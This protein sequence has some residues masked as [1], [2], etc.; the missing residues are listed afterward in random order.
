MANILFGAGYVGVQ[1]GAAFPYT[2][3]CLINFSQI[4]FTVSEE[5]GEDI[6]ALRLG[7]SVVVA[8]TPG[9]EKAE[10]KITNVDFVAPALEVLLNAEAGNAAAQAFP[11]NDSYTIPTGSPYEVTIP[12]ALTADTEYVV[13]LANW[14]QFTRVASNPTAGQFSISGTTVTFNSGDAGKIVLIGGNITSAATARAIGGTSANPLGALQVMFYCK[15]NQDKRIGFLF[16]SVTA[17]KDLSLLISEKASEVPITFNCATPSGWAK[18][19]KV[20]FE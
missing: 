7:G 8:T 11:W 19:Y 3:R 4:E 10:L 18:P 12:A 20:I 16:P 1:K 17:K 13:A 9:T 15:D 6:K 2:M 5:G 14:Q